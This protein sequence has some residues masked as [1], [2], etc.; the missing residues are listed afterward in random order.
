[1]RLLLRYSERYLIL[2]YPRDSSFLSL[3]LI[4]AF[5]AADDTRRL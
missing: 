1:M 3:C 4:N 5:R 2:L